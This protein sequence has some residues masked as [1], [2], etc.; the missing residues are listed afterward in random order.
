MTALG[1]SVCV[2]LTGW[3]IGLGASP[4]NG[5][6]PASQ[7]TSAPTTQPDAKLDELVVRFFRT[8]DTPARQRVLGE[9][10]HYPG[11]D[12]A[13]VAD[14]VRRAQLWEAVAPGV[15]DF[16]VPYATDGHTLVRVRVPKAYDPTRRYPLILALHGMNQSA[17]GII[18]YIEQL[19][20][21]EV[22]QF[23]L[24]APQDCKGANF[25]A[26]LAD[27]EEPPAILAALRRRYHLDTQRIYVT[28]YSLGGHGTFTLAALYT[29][30][31]AA[32]VPLAGTF[33][34]PGAPDGVPIL[35]P[36]LAGL[37]LLVVW[38]AHD[39]HDRDGREDTGG[40][41]AGA[42]RALQVE[43]PKAGVNT[44]EFVELPDKG[45]SDVTPPRE[46]LL[47]YFQ[48]QRDAARRHIVHWFRFP[49]QGRRGWLRQREFAGRPWEGELVVR[50]TPGADVHEYARRAL[51]QQL[52]MLEGTIEGQVLRLDLQRTVKAELLLDDGLI[53]LAQPITVYRGQKIVFEGL[54]PPQ[55]ATLLQQAYADWEFQILPAVR[56]V[57]PA[58]GKARQE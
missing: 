49:A 8:A 23:I 54:A 17:L 35:A 34:T 10:T 13:R 32:A 29:D 55:V 57:V 52:A 7:P 4:A 21:P 20:G 47:H 38:G 58:S 9:I 24:A 11:A 26:R 45:H 12:L 19:L 30:S 15:A 22:E 50:V 41:I 5:A 56:I 46:R 3:L 6:A 1:R 31:F 2:A 27:S 16:D 48:L 18:Q 36:N 33:L 53:D 44:A 14:S 37:P 42:N 51:R 28:G 25:A 43:L 39:T 40:G